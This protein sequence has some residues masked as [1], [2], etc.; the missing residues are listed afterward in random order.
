MTENYFIT[1]NTVPETQS[2][3]HTIY[4]RDGHIIFAGFGEYSGVIR[5]FHKQTHR[6]DS[7]TPKNCSLSDIKKMLLAAAGTP[8]QK[9]VWSAVKNVP[10]GTVTT[11]GQLAEAIGKPTAVRAVGTALGCNPI[12]YFIPCHRVVRASHNMSDRTQGYRWGSAIKHDIIR[13]EGKFINA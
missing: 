8:F 10:R 5:A 4:T 9:K 11:Y 1:T 2:P 6:T 7:P 12:S 3:L 13:Y